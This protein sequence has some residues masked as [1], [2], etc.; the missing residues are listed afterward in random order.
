MDD[1]ELSQEEQIE[2]LA[3]RIDE[4]EDLV[5]RLAFRVNAVDLGDEIRQAAF[6]RSFDE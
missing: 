2:R 6:Q 5:A 3:A 1:R 4:L